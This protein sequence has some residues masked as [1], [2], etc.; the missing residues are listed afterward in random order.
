MAKVLKHWVN[1]YKHGF[2]QRY[3]VAELCK[4]FDLW[5]VLR[6]TQETV[7]KKDG[8]TSFLKRESNCPH[9]IINFTIHSCCEH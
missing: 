3:K 4:E 2:V 6:C 7:M 8:A 5:V 1:F 9:T